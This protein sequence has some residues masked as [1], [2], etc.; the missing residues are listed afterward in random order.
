MS[1]TAT[2]TAA[3]AM[4][5]AAHDRAYRY[6]EN[7]AGFQAA[8]RY[9]TDE[10]TLEGTITIHSPD[11]IRLELGGR[12]AEMQALQREIASLC[13]HR[14]YAPYSA[15][16]G[17][18]T[19]SL[20]ANAQHPLGQL[21]LFHD[22]PFNSSYRIQDGSVVQIN[23]QMGTT[24]FTI[25][26]QEHTHIEE[27]KTLPR[28]FTVAYWDTNQKRLTRTTSYTDHYTPVE[29]YYLPASRR[30]ITYDDKGVSTHVIEFS[31]HKLA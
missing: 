9:R 3:H 19:L 31:A 10:E 17:R 12:E 15:G 5:Q 25:Q 29:G 22:D 16:D 27:N 24:R 7:F 21:I 23:R 8:L 6:P 4:L 18:Y 2:N 1:Q 13:A 26:I 30:I 20:D 11:T 14:W 28:Q